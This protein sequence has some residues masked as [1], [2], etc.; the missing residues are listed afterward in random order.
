MSISKT[1]NISDIYEFHPKDEI[2]DVNSRTSS[3]ELRE[4]DEDK[5][6]EL[7]E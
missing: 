1:F 2:E 5:I 3:S 6:D 4:N 7:A